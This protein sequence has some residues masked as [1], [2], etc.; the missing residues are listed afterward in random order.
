MHLEETFKQWQGKNKPECHIDRNWRGGHNGKVVD[1]KQELI[2]KKKRGKTNVE[3]FCSCCVLF[4]GVCM[5]REE[6]KLSEIFKVERL[7]EN[8]AGAGFEAAKS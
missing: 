3:G 2:Q 4:F 7:L 8:F 1:G 5:T 6:P